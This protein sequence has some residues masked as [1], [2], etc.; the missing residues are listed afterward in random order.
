MCLTPAGPI[1]RLDESFSLTV[2]YSSISN[3]VSQSVS[4]T[5]LFHGYKDYN[6][7]NDYNDDNDDSDDNDDNDDNDDSDYN[8]YIDSDLDLD[9]D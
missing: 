7:Y 9:L 4:E 5:F 3:V 6:D 2:Q 1:P 8:D